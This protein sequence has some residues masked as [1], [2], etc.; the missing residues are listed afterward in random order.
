MINKGLF[1]N[2]SDNWTT[3]QELFDEL[4]KEFHFTLDVCASKDNTKCSKYFTKEDNAL[5]QDWT[6]EIC[7]MNPP[8]SRIQDKL[9]EKAKEES[10]KGTTIVCLIPARTDTKRFHNYVWDTKNNKSRERVEVRFIKGR[11]KFGDS[12]NPAPFPS[13]I[14]VFRGLK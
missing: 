1:S 5:L 7:F 13:M 6:N 4:N 14:V 2:N 3:P 9:I 8:Y 11:L 12:T 10:D